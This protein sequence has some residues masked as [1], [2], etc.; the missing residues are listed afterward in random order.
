MLTYC[1]DEATY[2]TDYQPA[3]QPRLLFVCKTSGEES[4]IPGSCINITIGWN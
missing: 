4:A 2:C 1:Q 3:S